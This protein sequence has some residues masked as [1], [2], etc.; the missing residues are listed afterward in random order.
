MR[1]LHAVLIFLFAVSAEICYSQ[2]EHWSEKM[3]DHSVNFYDVQESFNDYWE[4]QIIEKGK[5]WKQFKRWEYFWEQRLYPTGEKIN[6]AQL[7]I[8]YRN[9]I[10]QNPQL[11]AT[12]GSWTYT[13]NTSV[14]TNAGGAGRVNC[15]AFD[16]GNNNIIYAGTPAGGIWKSIN[17]GIT[18]S[19]VTDDLP[20]MGFST[21]AV[22]PDSTNVIYAGTGDH[23]AGDTYSIGVL[24]STD[25]GATWNATGLTF[26]I[27]SGITVNKILID[28]T[29]TNIVLAATNSGTYRSTDAGNSWVIT[30]SGNARDLEFK[31]DDPTIVYATK[32]NS[33]YRSANNG[34]SFSI[35]NGTGF[36]AQ[37]TV[38]RIALAV[39]P[40][41]P[42]YVYVLAGKSVSNGFNGVYRSDDA[43]LTFA[44]QSDYPN[45]LGWENDGS[46]VG[47][48]AW[49]DLAIAASPTNAEIVYCGGVNV[50][51]ST[52][53]GN[54]WS[55]VGHW[56]GSGAPY[57]HADFHT[58]EFQ[59]S[60]G[61]LFAGCDGG[62]F[63]TT[64]GG[65]SWT[66][67]SNNME[68]SQIY[69]LGTAATDV[70]KIITGL[71]DNGTTLRTAGNNWKRVMGGDGM[72]CI[73]SHSDSMTM[74]GE[75][76]YGQI[77]KSTN[78][79]NNFSTI[80]S[81]NGS[82]VNEAGPWVTPYI[83]HPSN[84]NTLLV[85]K[86]QIYRSTN[87][88]S[89]WQQ[90]GSIPGGN[91]TQFVHLAYA[92]SN[93]NVIYA[94]KRD[95][96]Y[97]TT[98]S[99][100]TWTNVSNNLP[101]LY[102]TYVAVSNTDPNKAY[103]T[104]SGYNS[105]SKVYY[106]N[107]GG[108]TWNNYSAGLPN[109]PANCI[110]YQNNT[111]DGVYVG[112]DIGVFYRNNNL[113]QWQYFSE[114]LP[115]TV[116]NE[117]E[118]HYASGKIRAATYGRGVW[119]S[120]V[121][122]NIQNDLA[123]TSIDQP[124]G[125][126]CQP[127]FAPEVTFTNTG[128]NTI[129]TALIGYFIDGNPVQY[130]NWAGT[131]ASGE[132]QSVT[133]SSLSA[134][135]GPHTFTAFTTLPNGGL[136]TI[137]SNDSMTVNFIFSSSAM[138]VT[139]NMQLDCFGEETSW[140]IED[141][142]GTVIYNTPSG[143]YPGNPA[144]PLLS[145]TV[146]S[147]KLCLETGCY[148]FIISDSQGNGLNGTSSGCGINGDYE[149]ISSNDT[150]LFENQ[151]ANGNFGTDT[152][153]A[154]CVSSQ[155][156]SGFSASPRS[157]CNGNLISFYDASSNGTNSWT[158][159]ISGPDT[160]IS[161]L[162]N[163]VFTFNLAGIYDVTLISGDGSDT[164]TSYFDNYITIFSN[165][166][167][168]PVVYDVLCYGDLTGKVVPVI[169]GG[170]LPF[171]FNWSN[172]TYADSLENAGIGTYQLI[173]SDVNGCRDSSTSTISEPTELISSVTI[174]DADCGFTNGQALINYSGGVAPY[175]V[176][177]SNGDTIDSITGLQIGTYLVSVTDEKNCTNN[178]TVEIVNPNAPSITSVNTDE[179][180]TGLCN[181]TVTGTYL[182]G[183]T[184]TVTFNWSSLGSNLAYTGVCPGK[185]IIMA[186]DSL[187]CMDT[188]TA[189]VDE[190][191]DFPVA[192]FIPNDTVVPT[193][194]SLIFVNT[195]TGANTYY[196]DFGDGFDS[197]ISSATHQYA[198]EGTYT[199]M[200][201]AFNGTCS[202]TLYFDVIVDNTVL[203]LPELKEENV[204]IYPNPTE[205]YFVFDFGTIEADVNIRFYNNTGQEVLSAD[206]RKQRVF[207]VQASHLSPGIYHVLMR[208]DDH[209]LVRKLVIR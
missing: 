184:G 151:I 39:T 35:V 20:T 198:N 30:L 51:K 33:F 113:S 105:N 63:K 152:S 92:P 34:V 52:N 38:S 200:F 207:P 157:T 187:G 99:G 130:Y 153:H 193:N 194:F 64:N 78:G 168:V 6:P 112:T 84:S 66:D 4:N 190:G 97:V 85:G 87:G 188:D 175:D 23:D 22:N 69:R 165:P 89:T 138:P 95:A 58:L 103:I 148:N 111:N 197:N 144:D 182:G 131:L 61:N 59:A 123:L 209:T 91:S 104:F 129:N 124:K 21:L 143:T 185:Y 204:K 176:L 41:N 180:C 49:Y 167:I 202:D 70:D 186:I 196:W 40:A 118:I 140:I 5:G 90:L 178:H 164:D 158:W 2:N 73:I 119:E 3:Q 48:Q 106:T 19:T 173:L 45:I 146:V 116:V 9:F 162:Q 171:T 31:P 55:I 54:F 72:E 192:S 83:M 1:L 36:P 126:E 18:W 27:Q 94:V 150:V 81:S 155:Y 147:D 14:P 110:T 208:I 191:D 139:L 65:T 114:G 15:I 102:I 28:P 135:D 62:V 159:I 122:S 133:L 8:E 107:N 115:N 80:V 57:V 161:S 203:N 10:Q 156:Y 71:Q 100:T 172:G 86:S 77:R 93:T 67:I 142:S 88:G 195:S 29:N 136:D 163:P 205:D 120:L 125:I 121:F 201:I 13:G 60:T 32:N 75:Y 44:L 24:K 74:Y 37:T 160:L 127:Q 82:G 50:W 109:V 199:V 96:V 179:T 206:S 42:D 128:D 11:R 43:G 117:L 177:W 166:S 145:G 101:N 174:T 46:D 76:Y 183:G 149:M 47:G 137:P 134:A 169:S 98:N 79:G 53:G 26:L 108:V 68:I 25:A 170:T 181:G 7:Y 132:S 12:N 17:G 141:T 154:F 56:T 16:P 189:D